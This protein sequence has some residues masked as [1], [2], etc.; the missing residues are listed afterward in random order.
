MSLLNQK[1]GQQTEY[2]RVVLVRGIGFRIQG[3]ENR[4]PF[5]E[6]ERRALSQV[7]AE[8]DFLYTKYLVAKA[9]HTKDLIRPLSNKI[10]VRISKKNRK[11]VVFSQSK[12]LASLFARD[13]FN[14][15]KPSLYTGR[16]IRQKY[17]RVRRKLGKKDK[18]KG[19]IF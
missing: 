5:F 15:M 1:L 8:N 10:G 14:Y 3:F 6:R 4:A 19:K 13:L 2:V 12:S 11:V 16:G 9:G 7:G 18:Q 17:V